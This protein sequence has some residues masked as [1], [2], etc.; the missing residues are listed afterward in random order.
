MSAGKFPGEGIAAIAVIFV[1]GLFFLS[2]SLNRSGE[3]VATSPLHVINDWFQAAVKWD[4]YQAERDS[5]WVQ[6]IFD[7]SPAWIR[8]PF[9][10]V[11]GIFQPVLP[12]TIINPTKLIWKLIGIPRALSWYALLPVL[13]FSFVAAAGQGSRKMRNLIL[14]LSLLAWIWILLAALTRRRRPLG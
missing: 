7:E 6:K 11:Y 4:A 8:L 1:L 3:F 13:T 12:A 9:I 14:W 5:G 10:A 2:S